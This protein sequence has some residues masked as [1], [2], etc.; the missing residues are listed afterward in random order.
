MTFWDRW[1]RRPQSLWLRKALF[2]VHLWTGIG[3]GIYVLLISVSG[4]A[5]VFRNELYK[6]L[7]PGPK[8]VAISGPKL[9][10]DALKAAVH[11]EWPKYEVSYIWETKKPEQAVEVWIKKID[12]PNAKNEGRLFDPYTGRDVGPSKPTSITVLAWT[13]DLHTNLLGGRI[14]RAIN[15]ILSIFVVIMSVTGLIIW[16]PGMGRLRRSLTIDFKANW[17]RLNWDLHSVVGLWMFAFVFI[18]GVTGIYLVFPTP[19]Q[20]VVNH[21]TPLQLYK[22]LTQLELQAPVPTAP[23]IAVADTVTDSA[24]VPVRPR[25]PRFR[26]TNGD[27]F[28]RW[29]YYLHFGNFGDWPVKALWVILGLAPPFLFATGAIM[30]WNRVLSR[31]ARALRSKSKREVAVPSMA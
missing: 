17:K 27:V 24:P 29:F 25:R 11:R 5:I 23:I 22:P 21:F 1:L 12:Q 14:G 2:Q 15:G 3:L 18:W 31:E 19:F 16:W 7:W 10:H 9:S 6:V 20:V 30:W 13:S 28:L 4:S 8:T 26:G